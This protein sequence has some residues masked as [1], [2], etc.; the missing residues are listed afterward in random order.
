MVSS[1]VRTY[2]GPESAC[3]LGATICN[4]ALW[5]A[6]CANDVLKEESGQLWRVDILPTQYVDLHHCHRSRITRIPLQPD[7]VNSGESVTKFIVTPSHGCDGI[8]KGM[9]ILCLARRAALIRLHTSQVL[10]YVCKC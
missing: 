2:A 4:S 10:I 1:Q 3:K 8:S 9:L 7:A 6:A 5:D